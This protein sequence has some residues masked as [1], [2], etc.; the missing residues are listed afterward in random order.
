MKFNAVQRTWRARC[1]L[2]SLCNFSFRKKFPRAMV[3]RDT[4]RKIAATPNSITRISPGRKLNNKWH[5]LMNFIYLPPPPPL[6][7][8]LHLHFARLARFDSQQGE[9]NPQ[10]LDLWRAYSSFAGEGEETRRRSGSWKSRKREEA[11]WEERMGGP[12][13]NG[14]RLAKPRI[15]K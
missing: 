1:I 8:S 11:T 2:L 5:S 15:S 3:S 10:L 12:S 14:A 13:R 7:L 4:L 9:G 6:S